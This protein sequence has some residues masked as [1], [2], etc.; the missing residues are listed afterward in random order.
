MA[1]PTLPFGVRERRLNPARH[2]P[3]PLSPFH[4]Q[5]LARA[6]ANSAE[7]YVGIT[8]DGSVVPGLFSL[9]QTGVATKPLKDAADAYLASLDV[10][11]R[12]TTSF[13]M[14]DLACQRW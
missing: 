13:G 7:P 5:T 2:L 10:T 6:Q 4:E 12:S 14:H 3:T 9:H 8:T 11:Q 1:I